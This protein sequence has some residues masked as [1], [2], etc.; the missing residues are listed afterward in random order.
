MVLGG[1][2]FMAN[3]RTIIEQNRNCLL[4]SMFNFKN[5]SLFKGYKFYLNYRRF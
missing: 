5:I 4:F 3:P 1:K 2:S